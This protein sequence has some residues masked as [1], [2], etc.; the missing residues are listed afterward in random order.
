VQICP[1]HQEELVPAPVYHAAQRMGGS[2]P[3]ICPTCG[4]Q[5]PNGSG[6]CGNDGSAL[7]TIN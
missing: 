3:K 2:Y 4:V 1:V 6:F 7:E 5:Y